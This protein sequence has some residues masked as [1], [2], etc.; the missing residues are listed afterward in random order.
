MYLIAIYILL[1]LVFKS[2]V[3]IDFGST[4]ITPIFTGVTGSYYNKLCFI[5]DVTQSQCNPTN[6]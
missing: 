5:A 1:L 3:L 6:L 2:A 4:L